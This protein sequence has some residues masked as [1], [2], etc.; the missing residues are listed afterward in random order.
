M[1]V[2]IPMI[3]SGFAALLPVAL[4]IVLQVY[5]CNSNLKWVG[6]ILPVLSF[7]FGSYLFYIGAVSGLMSNYVRIGLFTLIFYLPCLVLL[8]IYYKLN[9]SKQNIVSQNLS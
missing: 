9:Q 3:L 8:I 2:S 4:I 1:G 5:L 7:I 6:L